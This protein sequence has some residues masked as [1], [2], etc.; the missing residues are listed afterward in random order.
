MCII[1][2]W[3]DGQRPSDIDVKRMILANPDGVGFAW[4]DGEAVHFAKG[5]SNA[6][7]VCAALRRIPETAKTI[8]LHC[9][10]ATHGGVAQELCHPFRVSAKVD[11]ARQ[12]VG[13]LYNSAVLF[14]NGIFSIDCQKNESD[15]LAIDTRI[16]AP[17]FE[18]LKGGKIARKDFDYII[19]GLCG[20]S[21]K[22][23]LL[24]PDGVT[25]YGKGWKHRTAEDGSFGLF[26][27]LYAFPDNRPR[28]AYGYGGYNYGYNYDDYLSEYY[29]RDEYDA[30]TNRVNN[31]PVTTTLKG[32]KTH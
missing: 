11:E 14:H 1:G 28:R 26:S 12:K 30:P 2:I 10:I 17:L 23:A 31:Y 3:K 4:N 24:T 5:Y 16:I 22:I 25:T 19:D 6:R 18:A 15:T 8:V 21:S 20:Y 27:N 9:R 7:T 32:G 13:T 29:D